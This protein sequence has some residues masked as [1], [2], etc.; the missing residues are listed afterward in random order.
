[1]NTTT[2]ELVFASQNQNKVKEIQGLLPDHV[3][4]KSLKDIACFDEIP[5]EEPTLE[6]NALQKAKYIYDK[7]G[8][9][10]FADDTGLEIEALDGAPGVYSAR[11]SGPEKNDD[12]NIDLVLEKLASQVNR[13]ARFRTV[14]ALI[15]DGKEYLFEGIVR[16]EIRKER[17]GTEGFGY[18]PIFEPEQFGKTFA[19]MSL[20]QKNERSHRSRAINRVSDFLRSI[21]RN[22]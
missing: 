6:G 8:V 1:M 15:L 5:E 22:S 13:N 7:F 19:E 16:G 14:I 4:V 2:L 18:D 12:N 20:D 17:K 11:F 21:K 10:C 3:S 9:N